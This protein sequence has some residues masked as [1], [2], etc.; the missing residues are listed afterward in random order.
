MEQVN[1]YRHWITPL[2]ELV[3]IWF[4]ELSANSQF[5]T[6]V[7]GFCRVAEFQH[8]GVGV[9][10]E[11]GVREGG[12]KGMTATESLD[13]SVTLPVSTMTHWHAD[14]SDVA[15]PSHSRLKA[16]SLK[17]QR[18][19][20]GYRSKQHEEEAQ[21]RSRITITSTYFPVILLC[22]PLKRPL[23]VNYGATGRTFLD[24]VE[25]KNK[26]VGYITFSIWR[27]IYLSSLVIVQTNTHF[28][29]RSINNLNIKN[30]EQVSGELQKNLPYFL[31]F[32]CK[33]LNYIYFFHVINS[34]L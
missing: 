20:R 34:G 24:E 23:L 4:L 22:F 12:T 1:Q 9:D 19:L 16:L 10:S 27:S 7:G 17:P 29:L 21:E 15:R 26:K 8:V 2:P 28:K 14:C 11:W 32:F 33:S 31:F 3:N 30:M 25:T 18:C 6:Y 5:S 13:V